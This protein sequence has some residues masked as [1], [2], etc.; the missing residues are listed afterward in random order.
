MNPSI[1]RECI[2]ICADRYAQN[3]L[4][5]ASSIA[6]FLATWSTWEALRT[7]FIRVA[8][9]RQ[10]WLIKDADAALAKAQISSMKQAAEI[11]SLLGIRDPNHWPGSSGAVWRAL[12]KIEPIRH[13]L[14]HGF[15]TTEPEKVSV[16]IAITL[17]ALQDQHWI[18]TV[19]IPCRLKSEGFIKIGS[20][21]EPRISRK[22]THDRD[23]NELLQIL[24]IKADRGQTRNPS[25]RDLQKILLS[26]SGHLKIDR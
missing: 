17:A 3:E 23:V 8:I 22:K 24:G 6:T 25:T 5:P 7:R 16:A 10:G 1:I 14:T 13:K 21:L 15:Q 19:P 18:E 12:N 4:G 2:Q 26:L 9:H 11:L 20:I